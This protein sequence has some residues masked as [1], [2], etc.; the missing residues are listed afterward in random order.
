VFR[1]PGIISDYAGFFQKEDFSVNPDGVCEY[2]LAQDLINLD[3]PFWA[4]I[5]IAGTY[6]AGYYNIP[7]V[8]KRKLFRYTILASL[9]PV[10]K[11]QTH[12]TYRVTVDT[13][14]VVLGRIRMDLEQYVC[15]RSP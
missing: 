8:L 13:L 7:D 2:Q 5:Q 12:G 10:I 4:G 11:Q 9:D 15:K 1:Y 6:R 3:E 14:E